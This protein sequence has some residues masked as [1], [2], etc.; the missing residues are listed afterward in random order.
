MMSNHPMKVLVIMMLAGAVC[1]HEL[2]DTCKWDV[3]Y[4]TKSET[5]CNKESLTDA[6]IIKLDAEDNEEYPCFAIHDKDYG[7]FENY[8]IQV[9]MLNVNS[10]EGPQYGHLGLIFNFIDQS[11]YDFLFLR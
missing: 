8:Q 2:N 5:S 6:G 4:C 9:D 11:N 10:E 7:N 3:Y 1:S